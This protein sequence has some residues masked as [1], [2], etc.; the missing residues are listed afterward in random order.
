MRSIDM[1]VDDVYI[2]QRLTRNLN[3]S[4][5]INLNLPMFHLQWMENYHLDNPQNK[6]GV[7][8]FNLQLHQVPI[9]FYKL[10]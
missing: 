10:C 2:A 9:T 1:N 7:R 6:I 3:W 8:S 5:V 4:C